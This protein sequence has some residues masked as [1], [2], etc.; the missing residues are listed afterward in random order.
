[1]EF[2]FFLKPVVDMLYEYRSLDIIL[3]LFCMFYLT[4]GK[5]AQLYDIDF[6]IIILMLFFTWSFF[7]NIAGLINYIKIESGFILYFLGRMYYKKWPKYIYQLQKGF[8]VI[9]LASCFS[10]I[11]G[12]GFISWG[13]ISTFVGYYFFKTDLAAALVQCITLCFIMPYLRKIDYGILL[14]CIY[15]VIITNA[16]VYYFVAVIILFVVLYY[17]KYPFKRIKLNLKVLLLML[18]AVIL[19][20]LLLNYIGKEYTDKLL[21]FQFDDTSDLLNGKNTQGRNEIWTRIYNYFSKQ[22]FLTRLTGIDLISDSLSGPHNAHS[23]YLKLLFSIGYIG[24]IVF[25]LFLFYSFK[26]IN[27][28]KSN[29]LLYVTTCLLGIYLFGGISNITIEFTQISWLPMFF[30][31]VCVSESRNS[32]ENQD[33]KCLKKYSKLTMSNIEW[34]KLFFKRNLL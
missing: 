22:D 14:L 6:L 19:L 16:R 12:D 24:I 7:N 25:F 30:V 5:L 13:A 9:L 33:I 3:C 4:Q 18:F 2:I 15:F 26:Y 20:L 1:M 34:F 28:V 32:Y 31:G 29:R 11:T 17:Q 8:F 23:L 21:L 10:Y 27:T